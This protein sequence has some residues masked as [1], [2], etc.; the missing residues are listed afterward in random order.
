MLLEYTTIRFLPLAINGLIIFGGAPVFAYI[1]AALILRDTVELIGVVCVFV[2]FTGLLLIVQPWTGTMQGP[3]WAFLVAL[4]AA[5]AG[6][7]NWVACRQL[8]PLPY[9]FVM[10]AY[11][12][13]CFI[14]AFT[15]GAALQELQ[16]PPLTWPACGFLFGVCLLAYVTECL[17]TAGFA[18]AGK[19]TGQVAIMKFFSPAFSMLWGA[20]FLGEGLTFFELCGGALI[21]TSSTIIV[22]RQQ[23]QRDADQL[24]AGFSNDRCEPPT[25]E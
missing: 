11:Q 6:G 9:I 16:M 14:V 5:C 13:W 1:W 17:I 7:M 10:H 18:R 20:M 22:R 15:I 21:V 19:K 12:P 25:T 3:M 2:S 23:A 4:F 8:Q 24:R